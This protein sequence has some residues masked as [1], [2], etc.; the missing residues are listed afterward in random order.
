[1]HFHSSSVQVAEATSSR[2][3]EEREYDSTLASLRGETEGLRCKM[4]AAQARH[5]PA[6]DKAA[7]AA[8]AY[9]TAKTEVR[10]GRR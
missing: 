4:E 5:T 9:D 10:K 1:M 6:A 2:A 3:A 8:A 7:T